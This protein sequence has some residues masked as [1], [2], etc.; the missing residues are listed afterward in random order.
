VH[1]KQTSPAVIDVTAGL[2]LWAQG[3]G[4]KN[5]RQMFGGFRRRHRKGLGSK[6]SHLDSFY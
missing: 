5:L 2:L 1:I 4:Q 6:K 3:T